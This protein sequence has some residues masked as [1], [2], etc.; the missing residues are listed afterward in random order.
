MLLQQAEAEVVVVVLEWLQWA[1]RGLALESLD[2]SLEVEEVVRFVVDDGVRERV[3]CLDLEIVAWVVFDCGLGSS[4]VRD[5]VH[6][7]H[8][9]DRMEAASDVFLGATLTTVDGLLLCAR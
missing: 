9:L 7:D 5:H 2:R 1:A 3:N 6:R 8:D 4:S